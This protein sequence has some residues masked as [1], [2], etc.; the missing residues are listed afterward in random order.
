MTFEQFLRIIRARRKLI[1]IIFFSFVALVVV[2]SLVWPKRYTAET[3][4][5][6]DFK[7]PDPIFGQ[8]FMAQILP[9]Y[10]ATQMDIITS[11]RVAQRVVRM[12]GLD[13]N[14]AAIAQWKD[15][16]GGVGTIYSYYAALFEKKLDVLPSKESTVITIDFTGP[17]PDF[18]A[19]V[20]NAFA[21]AYIETSLELKVDP[22]KEYAAWFGDR[23]TQYRDKL[24]AAQSKLS[25]FQRAN[26][27]VATDDRLDEENARLQQ[28]S[29]QLAI[30]QAQRADSS[31]RQRQASGNMETS[32]DVLAYP[33]IQQLRADVVRQ[34]AKLDELG[35]QLGVNHPQYQRAQTELETLKAKLDA[36]MRRTAGSVDATKAVSVQR[37]ADIRAALEA[38][39][40]KVLALKV[41]HD[42]LMVLQKDVESAQRAYD[43]VG[44]RLSQTSLESQTH[45]TEVVV[46]T[47][48]EAPVKPSSPK[49]VLN[50]ILAI[51]LGGMLAVGTALLRELKNRRIRS[52]DDLRQVLGVQ[53]LTVIQGTAPRRARRFLRR[54]A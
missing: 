36:E 53:V 16:G 54:A 38:Q 47:P 13:K 20:A 32:P 44:D 12:L 11:D 7:S 37:E 19:L 26:G 41:Q 23:T 24:Q 25:A 2:L 28:L 4:V 10:M 22:A 15:D 17:D 33:V 6:V 45:Q 40:K 34:E 29:S 27:I 50:T 8:M 5:L 39:K 48:A 9:S 52:E 35:G 18:A 21:R 49:L 46:L 1:L 14:A 43:L 31:S 51:F 30:A 3:T 42:Q